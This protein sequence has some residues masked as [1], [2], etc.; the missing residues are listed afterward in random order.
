[1][2]DSPGVRGTERRPDRDPLSESEGEEEE[3]APEAGETTPGASMAKAVTQLTRIVKS[4]ADR[5][6]E[7]NTLEGILERAESGYEHGLAS[8]GSNSSAS[9]SKAAALR[10]LQKAV[11][12]QP[13]AISS[14]I[15]AAMEE[16]L[17]SRRSTGGQ[18]ATARSKVQYYPTTIRIGWSLCGAI[19]L[20]RAGRQEEALCRLLLLLAGI[21]QAAIDQGSWL[22]SQE[23]QL[24]AVGPPFSA[25]QRRPPNER[26]LIQSSWKPD[27][28][29]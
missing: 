9:R 12:Q 17:L 14:S 16:D 23:A 22:L 1:M 5:K 29:S 18:S 26:I 4:L 27:G 21:D 25:F 6:T 11:S 8:Q 7:P 3:D 24:E 20:L 15:L 2:A 13:Q 28:S 19:D 10:A